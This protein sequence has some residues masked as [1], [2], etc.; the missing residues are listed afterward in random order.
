MAEQKG[1]TYICYETT[2]NPNYKPRA[3][4]LYYQKG[5]LVD[6]LATNIPTLWGYVDDP[7]DPCQFNGQSVEGQL[8]GKA[9]FVSFTIVDFQKN[10]LWGQ[11]DQK[12]KYFN[13]A[14]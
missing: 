9:C 7:I 10:A 6:N 14:G 3:I 12:K 1:A 13:F 2:E 11:L 4:V 5:N 8:F